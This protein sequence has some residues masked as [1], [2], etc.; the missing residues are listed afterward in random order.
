MKTQNE[1]TQI[2]PLSEIDQEVFG[3]KELVNKHPKLAL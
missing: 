3:F 1:I 2:F